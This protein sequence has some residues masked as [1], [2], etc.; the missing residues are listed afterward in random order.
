MELMMDN[1]E[2]I[3][4]VVND[5]GRQWSEQELLKVYLD[6]F[7]FGW[8]PDEQKTLYH[9]LFRKQT[10]GDLSNCQLEELSENTTPSGLNKI[11]VT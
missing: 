11:F 8:T 6:K 3:A 2:N 1:K 4:R 5:K 9:L 10:L 7:R